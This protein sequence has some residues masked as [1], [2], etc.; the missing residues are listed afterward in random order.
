MSPAA[1]LG[2]LGRAHAWPL[3]PTALPQLVTSG[4]ERAR[5]EFRAWGEAFPNLPQPTGCPADEAVYLLPAGC[6]CRNIKLRDGALEIKEL[7]SDAGGLQLWQPVACLEF[8]IPTTVLLRELLFLLRLGIVLRR[9]SY[10]Q[11]ELLA[12]LAE[13]PRRELAVVRLRKRRRLHEV[14]G[15]RAETTELVL[16]DGRRIMSAAVE[17]AE[18]LPLLRAVAAMGLACRPNLA[19]PAALACLRAGQPPARL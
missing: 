2:E 4:G 13:E 10:R 9:A 6:G 5:Y 11:E 17:H 12:E 8:P 14:A 3:S 18:P 19:Y 7:V 1:A 16:A 15:C